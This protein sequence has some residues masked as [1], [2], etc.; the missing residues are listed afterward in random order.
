MIF[1][2]S[3]SDCVFFL[4]EMHLFIEGY[5]GERFVRT[6]ATIQI[7]FY[8]PVHVHRIDVKPWVGRQIVKVIRVQFSSTFPLAE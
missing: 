1:K 2:I 5:Q 7:Q 4:I 6:P 3:I 8:V